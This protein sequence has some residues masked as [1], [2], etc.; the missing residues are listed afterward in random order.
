[1]GCPFRRTS[2]WRAM[3]SRSFAST[4]RRRRRSP[5]STACAGLGWTGQT[6][7]CSLLDRACTRPPR[8]IFL[9]GRD[10]RHGCHHGG[11]DDAPVV[12]RG[13]SDLRH[14]GHRRCAPRRVGDVRHLGR[15]HRTGHYSRCRG[16]RRSEVDP[17]H[18]PHARVPRDRRRPGRGGRQRRVPGV[19]QPV[20]RVSRTPPCR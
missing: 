4:G 7:R 10:G 14:R 20:E 15:P 16:V 9:A 8:A 3:S 17:R 2:R 18:R 1:M 11:R 6:S 13:H 5:F 12:A 19:L